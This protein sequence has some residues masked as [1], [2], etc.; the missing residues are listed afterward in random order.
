MNFRMPAVNKNLH[1]S[2]WRQQILLTVLLMLFGFILMSHIQSVDANSPQ[3]YV[4]DQYR[5]RQEE[6]KQIEQQNAKLL[7]ENA[8]LTKLKE[9][10]IANLLTGDNEKLLDDINRVK[11]IAGF[12]EVQGRGLVLTLNDKPDYDI[13]K[14]PL[15]SIVH[16]A[17]V[18]YAVDLLRGS[19]AVAVSING[20]RVVNSTY[21]LCIGP[22]ILVNNERLVP[23]YV[24]SAVGDADAMRAVLETDLYFEVRHQKP[25]GIVVESK[26]T[27]KVVLPPFTEVDHL[28][29]YISLLEVSR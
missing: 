22:T 18:R 17:D 23:P 14:D 5:A 19:G 6:L 21:I 20:Y 8:R 29:K 13:L 1:M 26:V 25:T 4:A 10:A 15:D 2:R 27:D 12:T 7:Q 28:E 9:Q 11:L 3:I 24:I 16:D